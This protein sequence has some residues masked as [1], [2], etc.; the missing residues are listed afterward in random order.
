MCIFQTFGDV[1]HLMVFMSVFLFLLLSIGIELV[2]TT[3]LLFNDT[4]IKKFPGIFMIKLPMGNLN[5][6]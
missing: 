6:K 1:E 5:K 3:K 4:A 2:L